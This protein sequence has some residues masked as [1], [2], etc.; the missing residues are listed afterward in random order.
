MPMTQ[1]IFQIDSPLV[2]RQYDSDNYLI[3][4]DPAVAHSKQC[5]LYFSSHDIYYPNTEASF[6]SRI[7]NKNHFEWYGARIPLA[8]K[9]IFLRDIHKQ[10]YLAGINSRI[11]TPEKLL[12]FLRVETAGFEVTTI[13]SSAGGY[14]AV[15][16]GS[17]LNAKRIF[18][19]N[20]QM[21]IV[22]LLEKSHPETDPLVFRLKNTPR[23]KYYDLA[24]HIA[25]PEAIF[26]FFSKKSD[27]DSQQ[28]SHVSGINLCKI[29]FHTNHH[30]IP[31][32]KC[33]VARVLSLELRELKRL[34][35]NSHNPLV[36]SIRMA[37]L[38]PCLLFIIR[39][40]IKRL[41]KG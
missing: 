31:F 35:Q 19:F 25:H 18:S 28:A 26:Y 1:P 9:H 3:I 21:E 15:L 39:L 34:S 23:I 30:G 5:I 12:E 13:G 14:A 11:D 7:L 6:R 17:Q 38:V 20:G 27:W 8:R 16:Y 41:G 40:L 2:Q 36:F 33:A 10:W 4:E 24:P 22:S 37:G 29:G 32:L